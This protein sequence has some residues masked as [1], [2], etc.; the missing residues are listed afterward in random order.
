MFLNNYKKQAAH[1]KSHEKYLKEWIFDT[2]NHEKM[3]KKVDP[4]RLES[5]KADKHTGY[6]VN[7]DRK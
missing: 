1:D 4:N 5:I 2:E 7:L 6:A 3:L